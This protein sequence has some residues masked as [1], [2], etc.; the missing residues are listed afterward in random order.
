MGHRTSSKII[1]KDLVVT[2]SLQGW[3][4]LTMYCSGGIDHRYQNG[5]C[6]SLKKT[7]EEEKQNEEE[8]HSEDGH[9]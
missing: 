9:Q 4:W 2:T 1:A 5:F 7:A 8:S 3:Y 6:Q